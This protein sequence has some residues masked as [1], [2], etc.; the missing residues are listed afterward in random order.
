VV[1]PAEFAAHTVSI[2]PVRA[3]AA[4]S[5]IAARSGRHGST[6]TEDEILDRLLK[7]YGM[8]YAVELMRR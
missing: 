6:V 1:P 5:T 7:V 8:G 3:R 4:V 2:D